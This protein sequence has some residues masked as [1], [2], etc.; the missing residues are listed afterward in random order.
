MVGSLNLYEEYREKT[1][2]EDTLGKFFL[3][4]VESSHQNSEMSLVSAG[5]NFLCL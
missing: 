3:W 2:P 5:L 1:P 4:L